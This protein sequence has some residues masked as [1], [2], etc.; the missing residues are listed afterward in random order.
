M[1]K[2]DEEKEPPIEYPPSN[3]VYCPDNSHFR[4]KDACLHDACMRFVICFSHLHLDEFGNANPMIRRRERESNDVSVNGLRRS[5]PKTIGDIPDK[6]LSITIIDE[7]D[8]PSDP[9]L[10]VVHVASYRSVCDKPN[11][12]EVKKKKVGTPRV[13][14]FGKGEP[15]EITEPPE[16]FEEPVNQ[17]L[18]RRK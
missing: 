10:P 12:Q 6:I 16:A 11:T 14:P 9:R 13:K 15:N 8:I 5:R 1:A 17:G 3:F 18:R 7:T 4:H 2:E